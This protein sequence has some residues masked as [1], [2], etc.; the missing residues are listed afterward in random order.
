MTLIS[1]NLSLIGVII[2]SNGCA[3]VELSFYLR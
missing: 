1:W 2:L 3:N